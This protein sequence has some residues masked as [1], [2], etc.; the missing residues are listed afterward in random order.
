MHVLGGV[1]YR[2]QDVQR[3][4]LVVPPPEQEPERAPE[5][6][7]VITTAVANAPEEAPDADAS[8]AGRRGRSGSK[9]SG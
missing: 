1:R 5:Q 3:L 4:G 7:P 6:E 2:A 8:A 9:A